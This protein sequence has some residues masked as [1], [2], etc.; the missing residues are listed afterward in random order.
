MDFKV[1]HSTLRDL[2]KGKYQ[3]SLS[4]K[5]HREYYKK[6]KVKVE[7]NQFFKFSKWKYIFTPYNRFTRGPEKK[8]KNLGIK[9]AYKTNKGNPND[10][11]MR[12]P[13]SLEYVI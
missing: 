8:L 12:V 13:K 4:L 9:A 1:F 5:L 3:K 6:E 7:N 2:R 10:K 11:K